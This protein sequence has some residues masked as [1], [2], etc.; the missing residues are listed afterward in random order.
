MLLV[1]EAVKGFCILGEKRGKREEER[2][3][4]KRRGKGKRAWVES[5][6]PNFG[7]KIWTEIGSKTKLKGTS[8][9]D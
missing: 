1:L 4:E 8:S 3:V 9:S 7:P 2:G 6:G 5:F